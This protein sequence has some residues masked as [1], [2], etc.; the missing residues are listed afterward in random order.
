MLQFLMII[1][2]VESRSKL[3]LIYETYHKEMYGMST[4]C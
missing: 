4:L 1:D 3:E 2:N